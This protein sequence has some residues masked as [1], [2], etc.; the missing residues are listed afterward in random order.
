M[1]S[2]TELISTLIEQVDTTLDVFQ[3]LRD[4]LPD[5]EWERMCDHELLGPLL[6]SL[7]DLEYTVDP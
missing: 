5:E 6:D 2:L 7:S 3:Q 4:R 1:A